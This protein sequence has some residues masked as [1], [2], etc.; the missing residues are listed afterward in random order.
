M[1]QP[2]WTLVYPIMAF[3]LLA[4]IVLSYFLLFRLKIDDQK[5]YVAQD[6]NVFI[7]VQFVGIICGLAG[8]AITSLGFVYPR[9]WSL[10]IH[11]TITTILVL[12]PYILVVLYWVYFKLKEKS[13]Q[14]Y[15]EKQLQ[16]IYKSAVVTLFVSVA[17]MIFLFAANYNNLTGVV[18]VLWLPL[19]LFFVLLFFSLGNFYFSGKY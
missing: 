12:M 1:A 16:D 9:G 10:V 18:S 3:Q 2:E 8:L 15:D 19:Y 5:P 7:I 4:T 6:N 17:Y 14:L 11:S 13:K